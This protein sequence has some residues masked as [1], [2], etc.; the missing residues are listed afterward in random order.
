MG[1]KIILKFNGVDS[2][3]NVWVNGK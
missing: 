2:S 1:E 3:Y